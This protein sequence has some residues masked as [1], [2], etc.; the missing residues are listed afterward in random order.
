MITSNIRGLPTEV[1]VGRTHGLDRDS[2]VNCD[3]LVTVRTSTL[4]RRRGEL[5]PE[6]L[7]RLG[8]AL[9]LALDLG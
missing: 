2:A 6:S 7:D 5:D 1:P 9:R 4:G 3:N 8:S